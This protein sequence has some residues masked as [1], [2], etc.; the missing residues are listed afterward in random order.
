MKKLLS[1]AGAALAFGLVAATPSFAAPIS[2]KIFIGPAFLGSV[3]IDYTANTVSFTP[4]GDANAEITNLEGDYTNIAAPLTINYKQINYGSAPGAITPGDLVWEVTDGQSATYNASNTNFTLTS[5]TLISEGASIFGL[6]GT[7]IAKLAGFDDTPGFWSFSAN[8]T[9][10][11]VQFNWSSTNISP[12]PS[13]PDSGTTVAFLG[14]AL[15]AMGLIS[16]RRV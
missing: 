14:A 3:A 8:R 13:V 10:G 11:Q 6:T 2:G 9:S 12:I 15:V 7:G 16:R 4:S 1:L 5:V